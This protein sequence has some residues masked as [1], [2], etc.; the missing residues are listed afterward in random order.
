MTGNKPWRAEPADQTENSTV[1]HG[2]ACMANR[3]GQENRPDRRRRALL[4]GLIGWSL[5][6][7]WLRSDAARAADVNPTKMRA[8]PGDQLVFKSGDRK[9]EVIAF[10][11]VVAGARPLVGYPYDP[12]ND[13]LRRGS[14]LNQILVVRLAEEE[15][16]DQVRERAVDGVIAYS[17]ICT[18]QNCPVTGWHPDRQQFICPCHETYYDPKDGARVVSGPAR[19]ALPAL[20]LTVKDGVLIA[21]G[22]LTGKVGRPKPS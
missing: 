8:Q 4:G 7:L 11:D 15:Y 18:H 1:D 19:R 22:G 3:R 12:V 21:A 5:V 2:C 9:G 10:A 17:A 16:S 13:V 6:P 14:R 20:P